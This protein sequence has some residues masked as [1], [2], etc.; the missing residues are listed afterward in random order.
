LEC[1]GQV[2][3]LFSVHRS[4]RDVTG[5]MCRRI[6]AH[7]TTR[8]EGHR[9]TYGEIL[10]RGRIRA[11]PARGLCPATGVRVVPVLSGKG[12][13]GRGDHPPAPSAASLRRPNRP[14]LLS[15]PA[16]AY[17][18]LDV[19][20]FWVDDRPVVWDRANRK[21]IAADHPERAISAQEVEEA[22]IDPN[23]VEVYLSRR[24]A[25]QVIGRTA[26]ARWL[27]VIW[28]DQPEGRYPIHARAASRRIIRRVSQ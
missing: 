26:G 28:I 16:G 21:H 5:S 8:H 13:L 7:R 15:P 10:P 9:L 11:E 3:L 2:A 27:V 4:V 24:E 23:R 19:Y 25:H 12:E 1:G 22:L 17:C 14:T 20:T 18:P 6:R